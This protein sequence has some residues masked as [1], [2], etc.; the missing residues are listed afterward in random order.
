M[1]LNRGQLQQLEHSQNAI[2]LS[3]LALKNFLSSLEMA[4]ECIWK[5]WIEESK[6]F[7]AVWTESVTM[8]I[9]E[10]SGSLTA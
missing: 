3:L 1:D 2:E 10:I 9:F 6:I 8:I 7:L 4:A 5:G